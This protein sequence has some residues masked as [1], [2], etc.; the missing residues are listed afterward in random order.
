M[1][2]VGLKKIGFVFLIIILA[3]GG[4]LY[5]LWSQ[6]TNLP[7]WYT[8]GSVSTEE[9]SVII[10]GEAIEDIKKEVERKIED[11]IG[12]SHARG[13]HVEVAL[14]EREANGLFASL[15]TESSE[16][17][18]YLK[19]IKAS[20]I[21]IRDGN[22]D[23]GVV[24]NTSDIFMDRPEE[25]AED[26]G[27]RVINIPGFLKDR[28]I[29][30]GLV[31]KYGLKNGRLKLDENGKIRIGAFS[32]SLSNALKRLGVS[33]DRLR[34]T[35]KDLELGKLKINN[36]ETVKNTLLLKGSLD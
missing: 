26:T 29:Y 32:F 27:P 25:E 19:A 9:G 20:K 16:K 14:D 10:Y 30:L 6:A 36:I 35:I 12:K 7:E 23:F 1:E 21:S 34:R 8:T 28:E 22:L 31:G 2:V 24:V 3:A 18:E 5:Y 17:Y 13:G 33:E 11:A 4:F 15:I